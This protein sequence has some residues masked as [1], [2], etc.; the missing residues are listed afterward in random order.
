MD[1]VAVMER[2]YVLIIEAKRSTLGEAMKQCLLSMKD[3]WD[4]NGGGIL[5]GFVT[6]VESWQMIRV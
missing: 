6:T 4:N 5:Y 3:A 1:F 2:S